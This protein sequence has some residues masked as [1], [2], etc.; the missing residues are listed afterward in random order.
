MWLPNI[1]IAFFTNA[2]LKTVIA[3]AEAD[4]RFFAARWADHE[5]VREV[6]WPFELHDL[7][8]NLLIARL[9]CFAMPLE[10][11][12]TLHHD[13]IFFGQHGENFAPLA[14][15]FTGDDFDGVTLLD[16]LHVNPPPLTG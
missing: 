16:T 7:R 8:G 5:Y 6:N 15:V 11:V 12:D 4:A 10:D 14:Q 2:N 1:R 3:D 9:P 13:T